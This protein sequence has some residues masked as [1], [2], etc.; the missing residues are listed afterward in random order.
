MSR[1]LSPADAAQLRKF[2]ALFDSDNEGERCNALAMAKR[3]ADKACVRLAEC[4][5]IGSECKPALRPIPVPP[6]SSRTRM[7][8]ACRDASH[9]FTAWESHF[10]TG[11]ERSSVLSPRQVEILTGL[12][13]KALEHFDRRAA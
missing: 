1:H 8:L 10:L 3:V 2:V 4:L 5:T 12:Y 9:L 11:V 7:I 13:N 6:T